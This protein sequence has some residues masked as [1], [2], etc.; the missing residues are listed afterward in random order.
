MASTILRGGR[1][2][3]DEVVRTMTVY[4]RAAVD[5][6]SLREGLFRLRLEE[7]SWRRR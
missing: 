4:W 5:C 7:G 3:R 1:S 2:S 6:G